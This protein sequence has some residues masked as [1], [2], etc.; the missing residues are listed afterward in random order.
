[1]SR[2]Y[3]ALAR[4]GRDAD[5]KTGVEWRAL[6]VTEAAEAPPV[7]PSVVEPSVV[8]REAVEAEAVEAGGV[9]TAAPIQEATASTVTVTATVVA[10]VSRRL[11]L[12]PFA[13][14]PVPLEEYRRLRTKVLQ[15]CGA[16][17]LR[18][19]LVAS[20]SPQEGKTLTLL[21]LA[22]SFSMLPSFRILVVDGD[23]RKGSFADW[24][25]VDD[26]LPGL[27]NLIDGSATVQDVVLQSDDLPM[28]FVLRGNS[29]VPELLNSPHLRE[30]FDAISAGFDLVLVDSPPV[31]LVADAHQL[32]NSCDAVLLVARAF[33]TTRKTFE[34][35]V[36]ELAPARVL[37]TVLNG[38]PVHRSRSYGYYRRETK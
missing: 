36:Q 6:Q 22:L 34:K 1:M 9:A 19:I 7:E 38:A 26:K 37:G 23:L 30:H 10:N 31:H 27:S 35:T 32:A 28:H 12:L 18:R 24:L 15:Q 14:G 3:E 33:S 11:P 17:G 2:L 5:E 16:D 21:N 13:V 25:G 20:G 8:E 4:I 29:A